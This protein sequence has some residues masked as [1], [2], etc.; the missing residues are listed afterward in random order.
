MTLGELHRLFKEF[1]VTKN[2]IELRIAGT[3]HSVKLNN[4]LA[5]MARYLALTKIRRELNLIESK[6]EQEM[7]TV[8]QKESW[9]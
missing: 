2:E 9:I 1:A 3:T 7:D 4:R 6:Y 8:P 5:D